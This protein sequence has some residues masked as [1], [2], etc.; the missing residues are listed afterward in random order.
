MTFPGTH[1]MYFIAIVCPPE[2]DLKILNFKF[3]MKE[4]FGSVVALKSPAHITLIQPF[5]FEEEKEDILRK[6]LNEFENEKAVLE[7]SLD[8]FS[9]FGKRV[10]FVSVKDNPSLEVLKW[11]LGKHFTGLFGDV[12]KKEDRFFQP[13]VTF[14][15]RDMKP[16]HFEK[17]WQHYEK[18]DFK[19]KFIVKKLSLLKL[20][21]GKWN[22]ISWKEW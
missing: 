3:W 8:G 11:Q 20:D 21:H 9:H 14:A 7:I 5:W 10:L 4:Q 12:I 22:V 16:G 19:E 17:A 1:K 18:I 15:S 6:A 13:H 2:T